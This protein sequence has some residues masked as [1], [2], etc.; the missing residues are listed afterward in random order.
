MLENNTINI[1]KSN[2]LPNCIIC[3][4]KGNILH[5]NLND[6]LFGSVGVWNFRKC[7]NNECGTLW[8]DPMPQSD[9]IWKAYQ[10]YYTHEDDKTNI[11]PFLRSIEQAYI[12]AK[13]GY[14]RE[15]NLLKHLLSYL[16]YLFPTECAEIDIRVFYLNANKGAK[17]LDI[18]CGNGSLIQRLAKREWDVRGIDFDEKAVKHCQSK[19]L[20][21]T[22]GD[23]ISQKFND[24]SFDVITLNHVLEHL[25]NPLEVIN[26]CFRI[27]KPGGELVI[28]TPNNNS[29]LYNKIF[30]KYWLTLDPPRHVIIYNRKSLTSILRNTGFYISSSKTT[31]RNEFYV[32]VGS[33]AIKKNGAFAMGKE[34]PNKI[35]LI[36][37]K[38]FQLLSWFYLFINKDSGGEVLVKAIKKQ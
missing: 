36:Y 18:G 17:L 34:K 11:F 37:G 3:N 30:K 31:I 12:S 19:G 22:D 21:V 1:I 35:D 4:N 29:W 14:A 33:K 9:E 13:Y 15:Q 10:E 26:E 7:S 8:L 28:S 38:L 6:R 24:S 5:E 23:L 16:L 27:L 2:P 25:F 20:N 32:Y